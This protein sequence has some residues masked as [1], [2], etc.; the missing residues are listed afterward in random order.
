MEVAVLIVTDGCSSQYRDSNSLLEI[1][2]AKRKAISDSAAIL[3]VSHVFFGNLEDMKLDSTPHIDVNRVIE[4]VINNYEPTI[5]FTHFYGDVN[6]DH[7]IVCE[8]TIVACRPKPKQCVKKLFLYS[9]PSSTDWNIQI[10]QT[11][12]C[13]N[14][15]EDISG[16]YA[17]LKYK[18]MESYAIELRDYPHP[19]SIK[20]LKMAD[21]V[22]GNKVGLL[23][24]ESFIL[25]R[26]VKE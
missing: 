15:Y 25:V 22:E 21:I 13:P 9:V 2:T 26:S 11:A 8:S 12:F 5:V 19:R 6:R 20:F 10:N 14:W 18:A 1:Q 3:G 16:Q 7:R 24:A 4:E 23:V 17:E